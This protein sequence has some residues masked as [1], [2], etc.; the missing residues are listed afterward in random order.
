MPELRAGAQALWEGS[1]KASQAQYELIKQPGDPDTFDE[2]LAHRDPLI[3]VKARVNLIVKTFDNEIVG[4]HINQMK[5]AVVDVSAS[6]H[7]LLTSDRPVGLFNIKDAKGMITLP[8]SPT[9]LFVAVNDPQIFDHLRGRKPREIVGHVNT[10]LVTRARRFVWAADQSQTP[11]IKKHM[12][13]RL[14]PTPFFP[15]VGNHYNTASTIE[16]EPA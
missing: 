7:G 15:N 4:E 11:F 10:H 2:Y 6:P 8:I 3:P 9:M 1:G 5:W 12:S 13:T 16:V 14:E